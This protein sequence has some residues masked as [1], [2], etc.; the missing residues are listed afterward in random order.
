MKI[1]GDL[2]S[3]KISLHV[4]KKRDFY[5][6]GKLHV[7]HRPSVK[8]IR[9]LSNGRAEATNARESVRLIGMLITASR[10]AELAKACAH[11]RTPN[12]L[13]HRLGS[14]PG[15]EKVTPWQGN[16]GSWLSRI[17]VCSIIST[18]LKAAFRR[19]IKTL[20]CS[21]RNTCTDPLVSWSNCENGV[22][23]VIGPQSRRR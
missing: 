9:R 5:R 19:G 8:M 3:N 13:G 15:I 6:K 21:G 4:N 17:D 2:S 16:L 23:K 10:M 22:V 20:R 18:C 12:T 14:I 7:T 1:F 11:L